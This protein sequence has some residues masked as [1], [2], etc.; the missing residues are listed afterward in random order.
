M[1]I[2]E[3]LPNVP[4]SLLRAIFGHISKKKTKRGRRR[5]RRDKERLKE[6][7]RTRKK[8]GFTRDFQ[9]HVSKTNFSLPQTR[10]MLNMFH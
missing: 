9:K 1:D 6:R 4:F 10:L 5:R 2:F 8:T 3:F 7:K